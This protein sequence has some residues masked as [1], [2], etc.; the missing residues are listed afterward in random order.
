MFVQEF[1]QPAAELL[2]KFTGITPDAVWRDAIVAASLL[3][4][5]LIV[6][7]SAL[8]GLARTFNRH[9]DPVSEVATHSEAA[10][11][12]HVVSL[13]VVMSAPEAERPEPRGASLKASIE[14][15]PAPA[16]AIEI[17]PASARVKA[18]S[19]ALP[20]EPA[21]RK[22]VAPSLEPTSARTLAPSPHAAPTPVQPR[23]RNTT[24]RNAAKRFDT[25]KTPERSA[26]T[27][28]PAPTPTSSIPKPSRTSQGPTESKLRKQLAMRVRD[29]VMV[30]FTDGGWF[31]ED[32]KAPHTFLMRRISDTRRQFEITI[33]APGSDPSNADIFALHIRVDGRK[34]LNLVWSKNGEPAL[35][36][37]SV[38][39]WVEVITS[40]A[41][42]AP[43][44]A[45]Q[46]A[47]ATR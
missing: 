20:L 34:K 27:P 47:V 24:K 1:T 29:A 4:C 11:N 23:K 25:S 35:R 46:R 44:N 5:V 8:R 26:L 42:A 19:P 21:R 38:G 40:W 43:P 22:A 31:R 7:A 18:A 36:Y 28:P 14:P 2:E 6:L 3:L 12:L 37:L 17:A 15:T 39:D 30:K 45:Q 41:F 16:S 9:K 32:P 33:E 10:P 13:Q